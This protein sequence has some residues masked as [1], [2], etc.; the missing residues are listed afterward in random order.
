[1]LAVRRPS[2]LTPIRGTLSA[3]RTTT[4]LVIGEAARPWVSYPG[5][6]AAGRIDAATRL[7]RAMQTGQLVGGI[8][9]LIGERQFGIIVLRIRI[10]C[11]PV[12]R[13][14]LLVNLQCLRAISSPHL[15]H[16]EPIVDRRQVFGTASPIWTRNTP[17]RR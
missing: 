7:G 16:G 5:V 17:S 9:Q 4:M 14:S 3:W 2:D 13:Q 6:F 15:E 10:A 12:D 8:C 11:L 1:M